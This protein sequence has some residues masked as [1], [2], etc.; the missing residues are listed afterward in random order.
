[1]WLAEANRKL[2][3]FLFVFFNKNKKSAVQELLDV[4]IMLVSFITY[5]SHTALPQNRE[6]Q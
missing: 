3:V 1:M 6:L 2:G 4:K 5:T